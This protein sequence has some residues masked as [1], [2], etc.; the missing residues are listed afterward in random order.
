[1]TLKDD[2]KAGKEGVWT[3]DKGHFT[4]SWH[5][6]QVAGHPKFSQ[7]VAEKVWSPLLV[8]QLDAKDQ[9]SIEEQKFIAFA[10]TES[11]AKWTAGDKEKK[12]GRAIP[13]DVDWDSVKSDENRE[14]AF[15]NF[16]T[17]VPRP[18]D[19]IIQVVMS[20]AKDAVT[21]EFVTNPNTINKFVLVCDPKAG[22]AGQWSYKAGVL[23]WAWHWS[24]VKGSPTFTTKTA[25]K[26]WSPF[27]CK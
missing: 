4:W 22:K 5:W 19:V 9:W 3:C 1:L 13:I 2:V 8:C 17:V 10:A 11:K 7:A 24:A 16:I 27:F 15:K 14:Q 25:D 26:I 12:L 21:K 6:S 18:W 20:W 23:T